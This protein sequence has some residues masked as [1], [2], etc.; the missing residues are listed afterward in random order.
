MN[1]SF[2]QNSLRSPRI[3]SHSSS[4]LHRFYGKTLMTVIA[5]CLMGGWAS[6][7]SAQA[8][9][10]PTSLSWSK[11]AVGQAGGQKVVTL[12]NSGSS[13]I[14]I[15]SIAFTGTDAADFAVFS[16]TCGSTLA[17]SA[18]C[19]ANIVFKPN[20]AGTLTATL[21]F[22]D[23]ASNSPQ[24]VALTGL[25]TSASVTATPASLSFG[26]INTGSTS[27]AQTITVTNGTSSSVTFSGTGITGT[28]AAD[29]A[30]SSTTCGSTLAASASCTASIVFKPA[31]TGS[32]S[33]SWSTTAGSTALAVALSG[34]GA[35]SSG[36]RVTVSPGSLSFGS[37]NTGSTSASQT[38]TVTNGTSSSVTLS[39]AGITGADAGDFAVTSTT[40]GASLAASAS[41]TASID[42]KPATTGALTATWSITSSASSTPLTVALSGTGSTSSG[43]SAGTATP[44]TISF[45]SYPVGA[46]SSTEIVT[47]KNTGSSSFS[48]SGFSITGT[49]PNDFFETTQSCGTGLAPSATCK[50]SLIFEPTATGTRTAT[51]NIAD[52]AS[53]SPQKVTL[54]GTGTPAPTTTLSISPS[55]QAWGSQTVGAAVN[56]TFTLTAGGSGSLTI[57]SITTVGVNGV[58]DNT[59]PGTNTS[60]TSDFTIATSNCPSSLSAGQAC[61]VTVS[62]KPAA[63]G[64]RVALLS[65]TDSGVA[66]PQTAEVSGAGSYSAAQTPAVTVNFGSRSGSQVAI[67]AGILGTEYLES[68]PTNANRTT[69][70]Q[71]GFTAAR[72][73]LQVQT[74]FPTSATAPSWGALNSDMAKFVAAGVHPLLEVENTP[75]FLQPSPLRCKNAA[76]TSVPTSFSGWGQL[77]AQIVQHMDTTFPGLAQYYE[78]WN[79]PNTTALCS[80]NQL[81]DYLSIYAAAAPLMKSQNSQDIKANPT[82]PIKPILTGGPATGGVTFTSLL[83]DSST[84]PYVDFY[85]YHYYLGS[86]TTIKDG[87]TWNGAGGTPSL[88]GMATNSSTGLQALFLRAYKA[89]AA[90]TLTPMAAKTPIF[91]DEYNDN[92]T[93]V[94]DCCRNNPTYSP[95]FNGVAVAQVFNSVYHGAAT[96]PSRMIYYA[97]A[98]VTFCILGVQDAAMDCTK[99]A[100]GAQAQPYPQWY[101]YG[102]MFAPSYLDLQD[103]GHMASSVTLSSSA[104][105]NGLIATAFYTAAADSV[106]IINPTASSYSGITLQID[107]A[108][109]SSPTSTLYTINGVNPHVSAWPATTIAASGGTQAT[110]D[111]PAYSVLAISLK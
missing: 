106:L 111:L 87:M 8:T 7:A 84:A 51:L 30:V 58:T 103:G 5:A 22:T 102:L 82:L 96:V 60:G 48:M 11:V 19:T 86:S 33:A 83:T 56:K 90:S 29:F 108:G 9:V 95:L 34:T 39:G 42:F 53:N 110:F 89:V 101:A 75:T 79:E 109:L 80:A 97:A 45:G 10:S 98:Q 54:T 2:L 76:E 72:Y 13:T 64:N 66:S 12:T 68:L 69:V 59:I 40:C 41:C 52:T 46:T 61:S 81:S 57:N 71:G 100:T 62:F 47:L 20:T 15:N 14:T 6:Y 38:A 25:G 73:R 55:G 35:S 28:N 85:S 23:T 37:I 74:I 50:I 104:S 16:K 92:Y 78:I 3:F 105:S 49:D 88:L 44:S 26:S 17:S 4:Y 43:G 32:F 65:V 67:P 91:Y 1:H 99:A 36:G 24:Q 27:G 18:S 21:N 94:N 63:I 31:A 77:A 70:V 93:F 107:N